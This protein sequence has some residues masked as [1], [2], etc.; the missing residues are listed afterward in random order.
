MTTFCVDLTKG[1]QLNIVKCADKGIL[2]R[3]RREKVK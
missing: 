3:L 1:V 2:F